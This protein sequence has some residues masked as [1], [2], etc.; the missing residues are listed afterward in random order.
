MPARATLKSAIA[1]VGFDLDYTLWNP[2]EFVGAFC[3]T[4]AQ[5]LGE[6]YGLDPVLVQAAFRRAVNPTSHHH[7]L[8]GT[9]L[10]DL[11][12]G[13]ALTERELAA[14]FLGYRPPLRPYPEALPTL[15][16]LKRAGLR[17]F[18]VADGPRQLLRYQV[19][20][21]GLGPWFEVMVFTDELPG[22]HPKPSPVG[23][24]VA[25]GRLGVAPAQCVYVGDDPGRD[26][27]GPRRLGMRTVAVATGPFARVSAAPHQEAD[28]RLGGLRE[29]MAL[30]GGEG[31]PA[32]AVASGTRGGR[33]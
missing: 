27:E 29:V 6:R 1:A 31:D 21:L 16:C 32:E 7:G 4:M 12:L 20:A 3:R 23:F 17:L 14:R 9:V 15:A 13:R 2:E 19:M 24:A 22:N 26:F 33:P 5:E 30:L 8:F 11:G 25:A 10:Q 18:L 28:R